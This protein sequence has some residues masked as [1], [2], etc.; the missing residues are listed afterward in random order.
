MS[1]IVPWVAGQCRTSVATIMTTSGGAVETTGGD[2]SED[3]EQYEK[4]S[5]DYDKTRGAIGVEIMLGCMTS[6]GEEDLVGGEDVGC[7]E[8]DM[9]L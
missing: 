6:V 8:E 9:M 7:G 3:Y 5:A 4:T 2:G 1:D